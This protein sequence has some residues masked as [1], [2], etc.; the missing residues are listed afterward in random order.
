VNPYEAPQTGDDRIPRLPRR[1]LVVVVSLAVAAGIIVGGGLTFYHAR[2]ER[3]RAI[4]AAMIRAEQAAQ[5]EALRAR[6]AALKAES[7]LKHEH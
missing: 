2:A 5:A 4:A 3:A 1:S 6:E 7:P